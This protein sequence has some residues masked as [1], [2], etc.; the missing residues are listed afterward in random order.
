MIIYY[1]SSIRGEH[2]E[3]STIVNKR[4]IEH[5]K[6]HGTVLTEHIGNDD[7]KNIGEDGLTDKEIHDRD[8]KWIESAD[9][10]IAEVSNPSLG[11]G[12]EI[13]RA[14]ENN[15]KILCLFK[16]GTKKLSA[17]IR[18]CD[19]ILTED[20]TDIEEALKKIDRFLMN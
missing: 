10:I 7:I 11:V 8:W 6:K 18:G 17:M 19:N 14:V 3:D 4:I 20:Y 13:G 16:Q 1:A 2:S 5:L 9:V 15:K 12:Y